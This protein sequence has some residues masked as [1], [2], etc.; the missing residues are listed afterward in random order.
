VVIALDASGIVVRQGDA[1]VLA[2]A[3]A[4]ATP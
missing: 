1:S 4:A 3:A 2:T